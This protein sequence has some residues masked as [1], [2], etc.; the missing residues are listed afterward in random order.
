MVAVLLQVHVLV[1][2]GLVLQRDKLC[3]ES[4]RLLWSNVPDHSRCP[5]KGTLLLDIGLI[6]LKSEKRLQCSHLGFGLQSFCGDRRF[7]DHDAAQQTVC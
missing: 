1:R 4:E 6:S 2:V 5:F 3:S 7:V